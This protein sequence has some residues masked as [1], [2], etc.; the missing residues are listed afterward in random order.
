MSD[1]D[2]TPSDDRGGGHIATWMGIGL[3]FGLALGA[4]FGG[5]AVGLVLGIAF[6]AGIGAMLNARDR[7]QRK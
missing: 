2:N 5:V 7:K 4:A 6:G 1:T 3:V